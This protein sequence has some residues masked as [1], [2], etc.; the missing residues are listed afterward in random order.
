[1]IFRNILYVPVFVLLFGSLH[2]SSGLIV[3]LV[4]ALKRRHKGK[5]KVV[6]VLN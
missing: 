1:M 4:R 3:V 5:D 6:L 2:I